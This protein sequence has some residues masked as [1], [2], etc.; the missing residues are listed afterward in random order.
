MGWTRF[1]SIALIA[2]AAACSSDGSGGSSP[3]TTNPEFVGRWLGGWTSTGAFGPQSGT[4]DLTVSGTGQLSGTLHN[5]TLGADGTLSGTV[6]QNG[7]LS[8]SYGYGASSYNASG[9]VVLQSNGHLGGSVDTFDKG[10]K[11]ATSTF[12][13][14]KQ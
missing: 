1:A 11:V 8:G 14:T 13:L 6:D 5:S 2:L 3:G 9:Q 7:N 10:Q 4:A 12:D